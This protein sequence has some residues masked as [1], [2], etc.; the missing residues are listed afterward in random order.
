MICHQAVSVDFAAEFL[1]EIK[2]ILQVVAVVIVSKKDT[3]A[4]TPALDN[5]M[6]GVGENYSC[7]SRHVD[8]LQVIMR[9]YKKINLSPFYLQ[10]LQNLY[11]LIHTQQ[12]F[13][14]FVG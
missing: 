11:K 8:R 10:G 12:I 6:R 14:T 13:F 5:M 2:E 4:T 9:I 7:C 1:L 3:L